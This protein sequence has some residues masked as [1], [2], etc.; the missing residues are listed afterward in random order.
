MSWKFWK[1]S[2]AVDSEQL[3]KVV[4]LIP[5]YV[6]A[7]IDERMGARAQAEGLDGRELH[8]PAERKLKKVEVRLNELLGD[9][10]R[11]EGMTCAQQRKVFLGALP[12][13]ILKTEQFTGNKSLEVAP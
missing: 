1:H 2:R 5:E 11:K 10:P 9:K 4:N 12:G 6:D 7:L 8:G 3:K 13:A